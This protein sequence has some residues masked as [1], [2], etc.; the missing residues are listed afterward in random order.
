MISKHE[1]RGNQPQ[2]GFCYT[3]THILY[4]T[5][6]SVTQKKTQKPYNRAVMAAV[7]RGHVARA[8]IVQIPDVRTHITWTSNDDNF[9]CIVHKVENRGTN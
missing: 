7:S 1:L 5:R 8:S 6:F 3:S 2:I 9:I 4:V